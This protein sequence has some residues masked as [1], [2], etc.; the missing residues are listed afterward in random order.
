M[1]WRPLRGGHQA[2]GRWYAVFAVAGALHL[3]DGRWYG[4]LSVGGALHLVD[5]RW[6]GVLSMVG[7]RWS[8]V[9]G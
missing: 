8:M 4:V 3:V 5:G 1:V 9:D 7:G 6:Y 2:P